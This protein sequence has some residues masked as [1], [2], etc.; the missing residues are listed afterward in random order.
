MTGNLFML[1]GVIDHARYLGKKVFITFYDIEKCFDSL[2]C[3]I[4]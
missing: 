3:R 1:R 2:G 4:V